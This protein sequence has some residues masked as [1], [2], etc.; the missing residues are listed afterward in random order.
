MACTKFSASLIDYNIT[1]WDQRRRVNWYWYGLQQVG[2]EGLTFIQSSM[3]REW[4]V[5]LHFPACT[6]WPIPDAFAFAFKHIAQT[7]SGFDAARQGI[8]LWSIHL[9]LYYIY[10]LSRLPSSAGILPVSWLSHRSLQLTEVFLQGFKFCQIPKLNRN[11]SSQSIIAQRP[12]IRLY[13]H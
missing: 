5:W 7:P 4:K 13:L 1:F 2:Q 6:A 11:T 3:Q 9:E 12:L 10:R 8:L